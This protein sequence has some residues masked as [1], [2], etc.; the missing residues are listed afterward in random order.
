MEGLSD[1]ELLRKGEVFGKH[2]VV[3]QILDFIEATYPEH[4]N[5]W[6]EQLQERNT[7]PVPDEL[8]IAINT[9]DI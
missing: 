3:N 7:M 5:S 8:D 6:L 4:F 2:H 1:G 9:E